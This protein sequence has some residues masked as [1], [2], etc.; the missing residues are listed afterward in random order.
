LS[1]QEV[2]RLSLAARRLARNE[3]YARRGRFFRD[4][5]LRTHFARQP[6][7]RP[8]SWEVSLNPIEQ[9]NVNLIQSME[10]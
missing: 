4:P 9:A 2:S 7:Y 6:W 10:R 1:A 3:I 5:R 8:H